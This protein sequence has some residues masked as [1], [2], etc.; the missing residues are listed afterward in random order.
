MSNN[1][2]TAILSQ[3]KLADYLKEIFEKEMAYRNECETK[4]LI[5][6]VWRED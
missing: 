3:Y 6:T 2:I 4:G 1:H 5:E